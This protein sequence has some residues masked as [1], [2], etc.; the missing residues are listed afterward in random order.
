MS[1]LTEY[2]ATQDASLWRVTSLLT[3]AQ[4]LRLL[5]YL[6]VRGLPDREN[7]IRR[8]TQLGTLK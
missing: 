1:R 6:A 8:I 3:T 7:I 5:V 2:S 4:M